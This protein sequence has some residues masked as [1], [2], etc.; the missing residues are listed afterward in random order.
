MPPTRHDFFRYE[1]MCDVEQVLRDDWGWDVVWLDM[2][3]AELNAGGR[4]IPALLASSSHLLRCPI[5]DGFSHTAAEFILAGRSVVTTA[6][7]P[8]QIMAR[9]EVVDI[10]QKLK[11]PPFASAPAFYRWWTDPDR[12]YEA[13]WDAWLD[14]Q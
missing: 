1:L 8:F 14:S 2:S 3:E 7:R 13:L 6:E 11:A 5:H 10:C 4:D 9:P 12:L